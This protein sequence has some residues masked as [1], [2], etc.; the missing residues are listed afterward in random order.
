MLF[1]CVNERQAFGNAKTLRNDNSS[2]FG[3]YMDIQFDFLVSQHHQLY[4][5]A[6]SKQA[7]TRAVMLSWHD[8]YTG[9]VTSKPSELNQT[10]IVFDLIKSSSVVSACSGCD[11]WLTE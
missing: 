8:S 10:H 5:N 9:T 7:A 11:L 3:K 2:R 6:K 4:Y 1:C